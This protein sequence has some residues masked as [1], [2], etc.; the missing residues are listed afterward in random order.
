VLSLEPAAVVL[1]Q[2]NCHRLVTHFCRF[3]PSGLFSGWG[4]SSGFR[5]PASSKDDAGQQKER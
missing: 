4:W 5:R 1:P 3:F 2:I